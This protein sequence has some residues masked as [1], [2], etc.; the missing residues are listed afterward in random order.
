GGVNPHGVGPAARIFPGAPRHAVLV[1]RQ[2]G[3]PLRPGPDIMDGRFRRELASHASV[4]CT[5]R[6]FLPARMSIHAAAIFFPSLL[7]ATAGA[8]MGQLSTLLSPWL[9]RVIRANEAPP[10]VDVAR[11]SG[12]LFFPPSR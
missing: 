4:H 5:S 8:S 3:M 9:M 10:F 6:S 12:R 11:S 2:R 7:T 1:E